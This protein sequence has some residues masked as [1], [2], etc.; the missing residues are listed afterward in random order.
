MNASFVF[1]LLRALGERAF[2]AC[3]CRSPHRHS[4][5]ARNTT[6]SAFP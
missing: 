1:N 4:E 2:I 5:H 6:S 3:Q